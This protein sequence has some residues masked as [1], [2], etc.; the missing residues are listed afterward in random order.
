M[1]SLTVIRKELEEKRENIDREYILHNVLDRL[2]AGDK[3]SLSA[4]IVI[5]YWFEQYTNG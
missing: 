4:A 2:R 3:G 1:D 5:A